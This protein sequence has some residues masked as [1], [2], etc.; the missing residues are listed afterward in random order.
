MRRSRN[1]SEYRIRAKHCLD[2]ASDMDS[3]RKVI[4]LTM[5][6]AWL[7]LADQAD[8]NRKNDVMYETPPRRRHR[9]AAPKSG[10]DHENT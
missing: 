3:P 9:R 5:A 8:R 10:D 2:I 7:R 6:Q 4:L 1:A